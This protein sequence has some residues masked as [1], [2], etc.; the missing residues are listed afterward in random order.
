MIRRHPQLLNGWIPEQNR[1]MPMFE[2]LKLKAK[3]IKKEII[4]I[5]YALHHPRVSFLPKLII[6]FTIGYAL[7]P[8]DLIPDFIPVLGYLDDLILIPLLIALSVKLI[9]AEIIKECRDKALH[10]PLSLKKNL[11]FAVFFILIWLIL[12][13][14]II[15]AV[16]RSF[17]GKKA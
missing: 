8:I 7:S 15:L 17:A 1:G 14:A 2:K 4:V 9:P 3:L 5:Y 11:C 12:L 13:A 6:A 10:E 16:I